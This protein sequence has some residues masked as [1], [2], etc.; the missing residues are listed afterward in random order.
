MSRPRRLIREPYGW[1]STRG[2]HPQTFYGRG[3]LLAAIRWRWG[4]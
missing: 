3:A 1:T 2:H 4:W